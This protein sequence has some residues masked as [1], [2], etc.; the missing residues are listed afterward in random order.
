MPIK[1]AKKIMAH[2]DKVG[3]GAATVGATAAE[4]KVAAA[5]SIEKTPVQSPLVT[6][7]QLPI[8]TVLAIGVPPVSGNPPVK[9]KN[10]L[11]PDVMEAASCPISTPAEKLSST[12]VYEPEFVPVAVMLILERVLVAASNVKVPPTVVPPGNNVLGTVQTTGAA[13]TLPEAITSPKN[14]DFKLRI[15]FHQ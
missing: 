2:S 1:L 5:F 13:T 7:P 12:K 9:T 4:V 15:K 6:T 14:T 8:P 11:A 3:I 10:T